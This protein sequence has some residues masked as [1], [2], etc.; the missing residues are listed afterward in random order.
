MFN[1]SSCIYVYL[2]VG[3]G[4]RVSERKPEVIPSQSLLSNK[5]WYIMLGKGPE[6]LIFRQNFLKHVKKKKELT[7][8][9]PPTSYHD[10]N[11]TNEEPIFNPLL[12]YITCWLVKLEITYKNLEKNFKNW[13]RFQ[14]FKIWWFWDI[15]SPW[16]DVRKLL[17]SSLD[18]E[19]KWL[20]FHIEV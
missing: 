6:K 18:F 8:P 5:Y 7:I 2:G 11:D 19:A 3:I 12:L 20:V 14:E 17:Y 15:A 9:P 13:V 16:F 4:H 1:V 10:A